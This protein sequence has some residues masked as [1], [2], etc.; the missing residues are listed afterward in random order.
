MKAV[1]LGEA[2]V[3]SLNSLLSFGPLVE[4]PS[5]HVMSGPLN[6]IWEVREHHDEEA[7]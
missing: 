6:L 1:L 3:V 4:G 7:L 5:L 2:A